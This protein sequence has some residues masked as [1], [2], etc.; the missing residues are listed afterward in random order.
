MPITLP[1][2]SRRQFLKRSLAGTAGILVGRIT[3][4]ADATVDPCRFALMSDV[5]IAGDKA[6]IMRGVNLVEHF[7]RACAQ[8]AELN[9]RP[10]ASAVTGDCTLLDG[11]PDDYM[12]LSEVLVPIREAG[13][14]VHLVLGNHDC[15]ERCWASIAPDAG[16]DKVVE[17]RHITVVESP[18]AN[19]LMLDSLDVVNR[20]PGAL[21]EAQLK[22]L[23]VALAERSDKPALIVTHHNPLF[24]KEKSG[25]SDTGPLYEVLLSHSNVKAHFFGHTHKWSTKPHDSGIHLINLP[26]VAYVFNKEKPSGWIDVRLKANGAT[27]QMNSLNPE[28]RQHG[29][30]VELEWRG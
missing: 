8:I 25:L 1:P 27:V 20:S 12:V 13:V 2:L 22:W 16:Q 17:N 10:A 21:G 18:H 5:H 19:W 4:A 3:L 11:Q 23:D 15:R 26:P 7:T 29:Q 24:G 30:T 28:H 14:P 6:K 9:P